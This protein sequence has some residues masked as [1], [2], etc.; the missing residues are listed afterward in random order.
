VIC[1]KIKKAIVNNHERGDFVLFIR[2]TKFINKITSEIASW[3]VF[4]MMMLAIV[5]V[6]GRYVFKNSIFG[7]QDITQLMMVVIVFCG[8]GI[9]AE[10]DGNVRVEIL[11]QKFSEKVKAVINILGMLVG[12][13]AYS[14]VAYRLYLRAMNVFAKNNA[15]TITLN[16]SLAPFL[17]I[18]A[19]GCMLM[20]LQFLSNIIINV[21]AI[22][23][24]GESKEKTLATDNTVNGEAKE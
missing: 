11:Y 14:L 6:I 2:L 1:S 4:L 22:A 23:G 8:F 15:S 18:A 20:V 24:H 9:E 10:T 13:V 16:I 3:T 12:G 7:A 17:L 5:D 21:Y 19:V